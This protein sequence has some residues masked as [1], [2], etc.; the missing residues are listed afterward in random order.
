MERLCQ[1]SYSIVGLEHTEWHSRR[2]DETQKGESHDPHR[3]L[4]CEPSGGPPIGEVFKNGLKAQPSPD[5][6]GVK[7]RLVAATDGY[8][9]T[10]ML[11]ADALRVIEQMEQ[12]IAWRDAERANVL[13]E[14]TAAQARCEELER[15]KAQG[16]AMINEMASQLARSKAG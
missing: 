4:N 1:H 14:L 7:E 13:P 16:I 3:H 10:R 12:E 6:A 11:A 8:P 5:I 15:D 2:A 9:H